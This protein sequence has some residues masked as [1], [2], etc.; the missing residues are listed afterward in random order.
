VLLS[1]QTW[2]ATRLRAGLRPDP[3]IL[4]IQ[5]LAIACFTEAEWRALTGV[6]GHPER[7]R[8]GQAEHF[9]YSTQDSGAFAGSPLRMVAPHLTAV[10]QTVSTI[11]SGGVCGGGRPLRL[12]ETR[13]P[14]GGTVQV[15]TELVLRV[16]R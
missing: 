13:L 1:E 12:D 10:R 15:V 4:R 3:L 11:S 7:A 5:W 14:S 9:G 8:D 6:A 2:G 16:H